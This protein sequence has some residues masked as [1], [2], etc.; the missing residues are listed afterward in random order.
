MAVTVTNQVFSSMHMHTHVLT[1]DDLPNIDD[2]IKLLGRYQLILHT[3]EA[4]KVIP[5]S[6]WGESEAGI[7]VQA[8]YARSDTPVHSLLH[9]SCHIICMDA[10]RRQ[11][12]HTDA[13]GE[14]AEEDAVCYLQILLAEQLPGFGKARALADMDSWGYTFRLGSAQRW[15]E[16]DAE[17]A[18]QWLASHCL[19]DQHNCP[20]YRLRTT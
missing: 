12:L 8:V 15:F 1:L 20:T 19:I 3:V 10:E 18:R 2:V 16:E 13:E 6:F 17:D 14:F 5:G 11:K 7:I 4:D 9:E